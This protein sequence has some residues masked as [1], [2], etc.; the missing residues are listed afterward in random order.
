M[1]KI[2]SNLIRKE[3]LS[4]KPY[5]PGRPIE[6]VKREMGLR[7]VIKLASNENPFPPSPRVIRAIQAQLV[8]LNRYP[9][10]G[11]FYLKDALARKYGLKKENFVV[12]NGSDELI[13]LAMRAFVRPGENIVIAS[14]TFSVYSIA[15]QVEGIKI[16]KIPLKNYRYDLE[17]MK[18]SV[19][20]RTKLV[21]IAN[22]DNP[23]GSYV[24]S[25]SVDAFLKGL[26]ANTITFMDEAYYEFAARIKD[27]PDSF[28]YLKDHNIII[29]R[30]FSK[31]YSLAGLRIGYVM[32][33]R[34]LSEAM[35]KTREP[36]NVN[37]L[38][39]SAALAA[40]NDTAHVNRTLAYI[41][42]QKKFLMNMFDKSGIEYLPS[43]TNFIVFKIT[44]AG[45]VYK[46]LLG[47]GVIVREMSGWGL[48]GFIR[49]TVGTKAEN[50]RF[51]KALK[52]ILNKK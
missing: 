21:Y 1:K 43:A 51:I 45:Q 6:E 23:T 20:R 40:L 25:G 48:E 47:K 3:I 36:F 27:Y 9:D 46:Q 18:R 16:K 50:A 30:T 29:S 8:N 35:D 26:P 17:A 4:V 22:P 2:A 39:Q 5:V 32:A 28:K 34:E 33:A 12:G 42:G 14:P 24:S 31:I 13:V 11:C 41:N 37:S 15:A 7:S 19:D 44:E 38:A 49:V 52:S 10:G